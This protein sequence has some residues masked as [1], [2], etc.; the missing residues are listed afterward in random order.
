MN[1]LAIDTSASILNVA[2][3]TGDDPVLS[4]TEDG[5][6]HSEMAMELIDSLIKKA[7]LNPDGLNGVLCMSG[8]GSFTGLR[9]GYSVAK[10][11]AL[12]L[13]IPFAA[14]PTLD[15]LSFPHRENELTLTVI[16]S[17]KKAWYFAFYRKG[18]IIDEPKEGESSVI[19]AKIAEFNNEDIILTGSAADSLFDAFP[20]ELRKNL[21]L[22]YEKRGYA[23]EL[24]FIAKKENLLNNENKKALY[25]GPE[26][27]KMAA[28]QPG[29]LNEL[30]N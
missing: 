15:C 12:S 7:E 28:T 9:V 21:S 1:L 2:L 5:I 4:Q 10:G 3:Q 25:S 16:K 13:S 22:S 11:L 20:A 27:F 14:I 18:K 24:I 29:N 30:Y 8:P 6:R 26:Y 17:G 23:I 19:A